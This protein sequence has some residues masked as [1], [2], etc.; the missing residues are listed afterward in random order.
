MKHLAS[1]SGIQW[2]T[3]PGTP[4][5][6]AA[7]T[8]KHKLPV[9]RPARK[10]HKTARTFLVLARYQKQT[11]EVGR[12]AAERNVA[13]LRWRRGARVARLALQAARC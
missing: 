12:N 3:T 6:V 9:T 8:I 1:G 4:G 2:P 13:A 5:P 10:N 11:R 7:W